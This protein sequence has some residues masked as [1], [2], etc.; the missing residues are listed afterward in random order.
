[1]KISFVVPAYNEESHLKL[2]LDSIIKGI[3]GEKIDSEIIVVN[4]ASTDQTRNIALTYPQVKVVDETRKGL[5]FARQAGFKASSGDL[6]ANLDADTI[7]PAGWMDT[8]LKYYRENPSLVCL[9]GPHVFY[10]MPK[11]FNRGVMVYYY[12]VYGLYWFNKYVLRAA[13]MVQGGNFVLRREAL[14]KIGGFDQ[15]FDFYGEDADIAKRMNKVGNVVF[16]MRLP[17]FASG[18]RVRAEGFFLTPLRYGLNY[19]WTVLFGRPFH[20]K[21]ADIRS[22]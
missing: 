14:E 3:S 1:M 12:I 7:M 16:T 19:M 9:S 20:K 18:R 4:N 15:G 11:W 5:S 17:I 10:D 8:V 13:S 22:H 21:H 2:C 6:V